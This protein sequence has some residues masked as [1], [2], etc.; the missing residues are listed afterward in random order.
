MYLFSI[1]LTLVALFLV[2]ATTCFIIP[3]RLGIFLV[4]ATVIQQIIKMAVQVNMNS[5][6][7]YLQLIILL[8]SDLALSP[9]NRLNQ[10]MHGKNN[11]SII[12]L[13]YQYGKT[14]IYLTT[15]CCPSIRSCFRGFDMV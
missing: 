9:K 12:K 4:L 3:E 14:A 2:V 6:Q 13:L 5:V 7:S 11:I 8:G 10:Y 15:F 1:F